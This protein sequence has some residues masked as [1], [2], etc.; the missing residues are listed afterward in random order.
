M[1]GWT[2][3][4]ADLSDRD[5]LARLSRAL[6]TDA[7]LISSDLSRA[8]A[9][10]D[11]IGTG[12]TRLPHDAGLREINFGAWEARSFAD[13]EA[14]EPKRLRRYLED[15]G[16]IAPPGGES[17][18][19]LYARVSRTVDALTGDAGDIVAVAHFGTILTQIQRASG[20]SARETLNHTIDTLSLTRIRRD[21]SGWH[22]EE[23]N[24]SP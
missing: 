3:V 12:R 11:A 5:A 21:R 17:W 20:L 4:P 2:D 23:I 22:V 18:N 6:P 14:E 7:P 9:T 19:D 24:R 13:V 16:D 1:N 8:I 10:A 15:P